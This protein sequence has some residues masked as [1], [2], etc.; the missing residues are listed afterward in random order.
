[1]NN[2]AFCHYNKDNVFV[3]GFSSGAHLAMLLGSNPEYLEMVG[4]STSIVKGIIGISGTY[5]IED[6][7]DAFLESENPN[8]SEVHVKAVFGNTKE[9]FYSASPVNF[10]QNI[11]APLLIICDNEVTRYTVHFIKKLQQTNFNNY[12]LLYSRE[13][14]HAGLWRSLSQDESTYRSTIERFIN[15]AI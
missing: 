14:N 4:L 15:E 5:D 9:Q 6:Y 10:I 12:E 2:E 3:G 11:S 8:M 13:L 7:N 1:M